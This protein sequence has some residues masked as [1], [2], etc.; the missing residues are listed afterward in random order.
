MLSIKAAARSLIPVAATISVE[1]SCLHPHPTW[2]LDSIAAEGDVSS[3]PFWSLRDRS[4]SWH[5][6]SELKLRLTDLTTRP[7]YLVGPNN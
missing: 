2:D 4:A 5:Q 6:V 7:R 1:G 3:L